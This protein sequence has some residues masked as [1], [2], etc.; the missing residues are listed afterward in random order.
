MKVDVHAFITGRV[1]K[2]ISDLETLV[3]IDS[4]SENTAGIGAVAH[5]LGK[6]LET[7]GFSSRLEKLGDR[8]V[9]CLRARNRPR[10]RPVRHPLSGAHGHGLSHG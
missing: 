5:F 9:P 2:F 3:N 1:E 10:S 7:I 4:S 8:G 6:R